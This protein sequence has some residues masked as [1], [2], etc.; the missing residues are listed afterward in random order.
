MWKKRLLRI[1]KWF[2]GI[3]IS[4]VLLISAGLYFFK[5]E[6]CGLVINEVNQY[7][8]TEVSVSE[9][10]LTFWSTFPNLSVD[11]DEVF[12]KDAI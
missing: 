11:F 5:D 6:I 8:N 9:V 10:D 7:L 2:F 12:I 3:V 1:A 4:L